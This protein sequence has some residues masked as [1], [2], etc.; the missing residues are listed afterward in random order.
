MQVVQRSHRVQELLDGSGQRKHDD[1]STLWHGFTI[2]RER[3]TLPAGLPGDPPS[4]YRD[5]SYSVLLSR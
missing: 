1:H 5:G 4:C 2:S 3:V